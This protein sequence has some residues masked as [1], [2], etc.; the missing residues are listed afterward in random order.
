M[1][2]LPGSLGGDGKYLKRMGFDGVKKT[3]TAKLVKINS[4]EYIA[5]P[6]LS[7]AG[8]PLSYNLYSRG[9]VMRTRIIGT[10]QADAQGKIILD[11]SIHLF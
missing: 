6:V 9:D 10:A 8:T 4:V 3:F 5:A 2:W 11:D 7:K 1:S